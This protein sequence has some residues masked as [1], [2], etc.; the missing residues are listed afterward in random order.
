M[1]FRRRQRVVYEVSTSSLNDIMFFLLL[2]FLIVSTLANPNF[3]KVVL[4]KATNR[5]VIQKNVTVTIDKNLNY[6]ING[7]AADSKTLEAKLTEMMEK[8]DKKDR[9][10]MLSIDENA[11]VKE[12]VMVMRI[13][14]KLGATVAL[15][16]AKE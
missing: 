2:F 13:G 4:P 7:Q 1:N 11:P 12:E 3:I 5:G 14:K 6:F 8:I 15:Q 16:T 10:I 9:V